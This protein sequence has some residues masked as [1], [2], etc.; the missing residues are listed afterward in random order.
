MIPSKRVSENGYPSFLLQCH[1]R[2]F[3][4]D[5]APSRLHGVHLRIF[6]DKIDIPSFRAVKNSANTFKTKHCLMISY[7]QRRLLRLPLAASELCSPRENMLYRSRALNILLNLARG[8]NVRRRAIVALCPCCR[9]ILSLILRLLCRFVAASVSWICFI[10][11]PGR[12]FCF[13]LVSL[14]QALT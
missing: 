8:D 6:E 9:A 10:H 7:G 1:C 3:A 14:Y 5:S 12:S 11:P 13:C 4:R 2:Y